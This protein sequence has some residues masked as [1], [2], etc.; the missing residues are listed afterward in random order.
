MS[1]ATVMLGFISEKNP[2]YAADPYF[3]QR[4]N[5]ATLATLPADDET[6][7]PLCRALF[8]VTGDDS[9]HGSFRGE[10][11]IHFAGRFNYFIDDLA[12]WLDKFEALLRRLYWIDAEVL[13]NGGFTGPS[14][15]LKYR[16]TPDTAKHYLCHPPRLPRDWTLR[17]YRLKTWEP[18][19]DDV[20]R[21]LGSERVLSPHDL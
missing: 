4:A 18:P 16:V 1:N 13:V 7:P 8:S 9:R 6:Y 14:L 20:A 15:A 19:P 21:F 2:N 5:D 3:Y 12:P 10:R 11:V 17:A